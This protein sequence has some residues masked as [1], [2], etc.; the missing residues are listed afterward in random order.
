MENYDRLIEACAGAAA[1]C[2]ET[3]ASL[4]AAKLAR[5][6][7]EESFL[8][9]NLAV[10]SNQGSEIIGL[11]AQRK[12]YASEFDGDETSIHENIRALKAEVAE[13]RAL[14]ATKAN[15]DT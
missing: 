8:A 10:L 1:C 4:L 12:A 15:G 6:K 9:A 5:D 7:A 3:R 11:L 2:A 13:L 14:V